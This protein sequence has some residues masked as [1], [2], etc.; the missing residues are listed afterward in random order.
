MRETQNAVA[1]DKFRLMVQQI[2][3]DHTHGHNQDLSEHLK[4]DE[5]SARNVCFLL[6]ACP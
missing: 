6:K 3:C 2:S 1:V 4:F 5:K